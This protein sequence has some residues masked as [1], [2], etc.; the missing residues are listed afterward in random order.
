MDESISIIK[1]NYCQVIE[2]IAQAA[3]RAGRDPDGICL[4]TVTKGHPLYVAKAAVEVGAK[5]LGENYVEEAARKINS[6][7]DADVQWHMIGHIQSRKARSVCGYFDYVHSLD[8]LKI[9]KRLNK[10]AME[11]D[12]VL[13]VL[14]ECNVSGEQSKYGWAVWE[15]S[16]WKGFSH[17][18]ITK[19]CSSKTK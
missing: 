14:L 16:S 18:G 3:E 10:F 19:P 4:V 13:P 1:E 12:R 2:N 7:Q 5:F 17:Q 8:R 9:A 11:A 6:M 15:K